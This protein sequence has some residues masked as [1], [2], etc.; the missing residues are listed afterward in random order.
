[1][2]ADF[3]G[4]FNL[5]PATYKCRLDHLYS[6][7]DGQLECEKCSGLFFCS[8][9]PTKLCVKARDTADLQ[10]RFLIVTMWQTLGRG[11]S[12]REAEWDSHL[13]G[14]KVLWLYDPE[15][16]LGSIRDEYEAQAEVGY[17]SLLDVHEAKQRLDAT[18]CTTS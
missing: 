4:P 5:Y 14:E 8:F 9:C 17:R 3:I 2:R 16:P 1:M 13:K 15:S 18:E 7:N 6:G 10:G 12:P 11:V